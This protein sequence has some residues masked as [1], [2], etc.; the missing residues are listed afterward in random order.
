MQ[1]EYDDPSTFKDVYYYVFDF[2][3]EQGV[4]NLNVE[5]ACEFW[6]LLLGSKCKFLQYWIDYI[7]T[8]RKDL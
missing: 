7:K 5:T 2:A 4:K 1:R 6:E 3:K 8:E